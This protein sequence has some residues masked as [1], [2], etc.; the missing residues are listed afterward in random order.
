MQPTTADFGAQRTW[1]R[2]DSTGRLQV[3]QVPVSVQPSVGL[4]AVPVAEVLPAVGCIWRESERSYQTGWSFVG[5][6]T[7]VDFGSF[8]A[9]SGNFGQS[10]GSD[11]QIGLARDLL[12][13]MPK[14]EFVAA[15]AVTMD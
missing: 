15:T 1:L 14:L 13:E 12:V 4:V 2:M 7:A 10:S 3:L 6:T 5:G 11:S 9:A 8:A